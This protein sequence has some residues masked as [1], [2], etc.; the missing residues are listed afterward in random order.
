MKKYLFLLLVLVSVPV[1]ALSIYSVKRQHKTDINIMKEAGI[2]VS[3]KIINKFVNWKEGEDKLFQKALIL[4]DIKHDVIN[5]HKIFNYLHLTTKKD[6]YNFYVAKCLFFFGEMYYEGYKRSYYQKAFNIFDKLFDKY[7]KNVEYL[8]WKSFSAAKIGAFI[9]HKNK[10]TFS[11]VSYLKKSVSLNDDILDD[12]NKNDEEALLTEGEYQVESS[13]VPLFG[14]SK[15]KALK[16]YKKVLRIN[17][18]NLRA[19]VLLGK[20]YYK[21]RK[22]YTK[23]VSYLLK[24]RRI[25]DQKRCPQDFYHY[26]MRLFIDVHLYRVYSRIGNKT[27]ANYYLKEHLKKLPR[28]PSALGYLMSSL[29]EQN[30]NS[31]ACK[32]ANRLYKLDPYKNKDSRVKNLC[33]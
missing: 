6:K 27:Q 5:A 28:T 7:S 4:M 8:R 33:R 21:A 12:F 3:E 14:G 23:A 31:T 17:P 1:F 26:Y 10:G 13:S 22:D 9:R 30:K 25:Y 19:H 2:T 15:S 20:F 24:G 16:I 11:G 29:F 18:N 32:V